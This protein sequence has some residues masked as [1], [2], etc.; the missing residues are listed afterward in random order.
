MLNRDTERLLFFN[1]KDKRLFVWV[2]TT[3][4]PLIGRVR[5]IPAAKLHKY[6][7]RSC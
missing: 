6:M 4:V 7:Y 5:M 1:E 2:N 3:D